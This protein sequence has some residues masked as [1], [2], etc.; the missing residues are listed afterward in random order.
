MKTVREQWESYRRQ[1]VPA[2]AMPIQVMVCRRAFYAG[3][4]AFFALTLNVSGDDISDDAG[5]EYLET[6]RQELQ[7]F[8][9]DVEKGRA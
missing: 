4:E 2:G 7:A 9:K 6:L 3:A 8:A 1:V 5:A